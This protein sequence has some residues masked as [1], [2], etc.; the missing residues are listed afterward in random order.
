MLGC[1]YVYAKQR[2]QKT[3]CLPLIDLRFHFKCPFD[4]FASCQRRAHYDIHAAPYCDLSLRGQFFILYSRYQ[5][6]V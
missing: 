6:F 5:L 3:V 2:D 1:C 4:W